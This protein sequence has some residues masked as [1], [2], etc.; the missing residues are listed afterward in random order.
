MSLIV[1]VVVTNTGVG[2]GA[3]RVE[4]ILGVDGEDVLSFVGSGGRVAIWLIS[5]D[6]DGDED[7]SG[8]EVVVETE[9]VDMVDVSVIETVRKGTSE[10][11]EICGREDTKG[12]V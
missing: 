5:D 7:G 3:L 6:G 12:E 1:D 11:D 8:E 2:S 4:G 9:G 10:L